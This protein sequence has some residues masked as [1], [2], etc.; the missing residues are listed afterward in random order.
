MDSTQY[1]YGAG[2][3]RAAAVAAFMVHGHFVHEVS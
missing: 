1:Q 2:V 3:H